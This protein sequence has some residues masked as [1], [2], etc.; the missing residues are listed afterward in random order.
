MLAEHGG[1]ME[2]T[3]ERADFQFLFS[4]RSRTGANGST[5]LSPS[6]HIRSERELTL[7]TERI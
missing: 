5:V 3:T 6:H 7:R 4:G 2:M 1:F